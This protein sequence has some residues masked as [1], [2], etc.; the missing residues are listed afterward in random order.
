MRDIKIELT[1]NV[2]VS[3]SGLVIA[4]R[5]LNDN[6]IFSRINW[7]SKIKKNTGVI[8]DYD[9]LKSYIALLI[10]GTPE[11]DSIEKYRND[12]YFKKVLKIKRVPS[13]AILRQRLERFSKEMWEVLRWINAEILKQTIEGETIIIEGRTYIKVESDV[14]PMDNSKTKKEGVAKTYKLFD[15]YAPMMSYTGESGFMLNNELRTGDAHSNC[16]GTID[17]F[18]KTIEFTRYISSA[19]IFMILDSGNDDAKLLAALKNEESEFLI[20]R[21]LRR[22][23]TDKYIG[24]AKS[25]AVA[26]DKNKTKDEAKDVVELYTGC[27]KYYSNWER[28]IQVDKQCY[29]IPIAVVV[30]EKLND[31]K[32]QQ[33]LIP[34]IEVEVYW[35]SLDLDAKEAEKQ[36]HNHG[37]MEQYHSE[38]KSDMDME[39]LPSGK[40]QC[41]YTIMLLGMISFNILRIIGKQLLSTNA[42]P[43]RRGKRLRIRTVLLHVMYMAGHFVE[44]ARRL[45]LKLFR[46]NLWTESFAMI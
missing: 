19:P 38:F 32:G 22:E 4:S 30:T 7:V 29:T 35:N 14:T 28:E 46:G 6:K 24:Y 2:L 45:T 5:I 1:D 8:S 44:H 31:K 18:R 40:F 34:D 12:S 39:R 21:N 37:T 9:I 13:S 17:Y 42:L 10:L 3:N 41:N 23:S 43:G 16:E 15:G 11:F 25:T 20:K 33:M 26:K 27:T 36:Y